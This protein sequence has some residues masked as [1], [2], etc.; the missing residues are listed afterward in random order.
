LIF[1]IGNDNQFY[2]A[3]HKLHYELLA[4]FLQGQPPQSHPP[5]DVIP[6][7]ERNGQPERISFWRGISSFEKLK[8]ES[9]GF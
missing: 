5:E 6:Q 3:L 4:E 9:I 8:V 2:I 1:H 7:A